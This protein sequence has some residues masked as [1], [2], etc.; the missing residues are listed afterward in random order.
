MF[1]LPTNLLSSGCLTA[2]LCLP[3]YVCVCLTVCLC[4]PVY[5]YGLLSCETSRVHNAIQRSSAV[6][7][8]RGARQCRG[9]STGLSRERSRVQ[10]PARTESF[11]RFLLRLCPIPL[12]CNEYTGP[13]LSVGR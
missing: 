8:C 5:I 2:C 4:L 3:A 1:V 10:I 11:L 6:I 7:S 12:D 9:Y 13:T